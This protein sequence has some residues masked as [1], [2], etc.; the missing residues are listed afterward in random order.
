MLGSRTFIRNLISTF[1]GAWQFVGPL[2]CS[3]TL[4]GY[5]I[6]N[7]ITSIPVGLLDTTIYFFIAAIVM[8]LALL[9]T[10]LTAA[11][12]GYY[13]PWFTFPFL[14]AAYMLAALI[15][16]YIS[17]NI[18][19]RWLYTII[20]KNS[21]RRRVFETLR[22]KGLKTV[23]AVRISPVLPFAVMNLLMAAA[24]VHIKKFFYGSLI[25]M[26]PRTALA[27]LTGASASSIYAI[28]ESKK[29]LPVETAVWIILFF[30]S[31]IWI[32]W[33]IRKAVKN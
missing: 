8:G 25:G 3:S 11:I 19:D 4:L 17:I 26:M 22:R 20:N 13:L 2:I 7:D 5:L 24:A 33:M 6:M 28:I 23:I 32:G 16:Y 1:W 9:P 14:I 27:F 12:W 10:T 15:G 18:E 30:I 21:K 29:P 31:T